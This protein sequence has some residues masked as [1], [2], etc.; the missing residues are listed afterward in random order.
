MVLAGLV[1]G[2]VGDVMLEIHGQASFLAGL[3]A[4]FLG[5]VVYSIAFGLT[6]PS[7][8]PLL[9]TVAAMLVIGFRVIRW[10]NPHLPGEVRLPVRAYIGII[11]VM[12]ALA[13]GIFDV[14]PLATI[15]A[16][17]FTLS[18]LAVARQR[19]VRPGYTNQVLGLP[20]YYLGQVLIA[21]SV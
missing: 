7:I 5:H 10:L 1:L 2:L 3:G 4:F 20:L 17:A 14:R 13:V 8:G 11:G 12:T 9:I 6:G 19:F 15:G 21:W 16:I 18:D